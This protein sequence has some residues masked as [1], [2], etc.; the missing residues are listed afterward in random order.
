MRSAAEIDTERLVREAEK[1]R[2]GEAYRRLWG[3]DGMRI[4]AGARLTTQGEPVFFLE[5]VIPLCS[6]S[7]VDLERIEKK[8][9][10]LGMLE[11]SGF[12]LTCQNDMSFSCELMARR[13]T[14]EGVYERTI[15][16][17]EQL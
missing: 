11:N 15:S 1:S 16:L 13:E 12:S 9:E 2:R 7:K 8:L 3:R 4:G 14:L 6:G 10:V 5:V 17:M